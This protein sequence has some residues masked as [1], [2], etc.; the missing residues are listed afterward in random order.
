M[1]RNQLTVIQRTKQPQQKELTCKERRPLECRR[2]V[3]QFSERIGAEWKLKVCV[4]G[5][6]N[7]GESI[8]PD[9]VHRIDGFEIVFI[10]EHQE[11]AYVICTTFDNFIHE[12]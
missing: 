8:K 10:G 11:L 7:S 4:S 1:K 5:W 3:G 12:L 2:Q 9:H 6:V